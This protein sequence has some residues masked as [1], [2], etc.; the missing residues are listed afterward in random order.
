MRRCSFALLVLG[1]WGLKT[2]A[3]NAVSGRG[4][5]EAAMVDT[6]EFAVQVTENGQGPVVSLSGDLDLAVAG[7]FRDAWTAWW[8]SMSRWISLT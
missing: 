6:P 8:V 4:F 2:R 1:F 7:R 5:Q 3:M